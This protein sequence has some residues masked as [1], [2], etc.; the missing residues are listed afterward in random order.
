VKNKVFTGGDMSKVELFHVI[1][2]LE[3]GERKRFTD[4]ETILLYTGNDRWFNDVMYRYRPDV[5]I[6]MYASM[7]RLRGSTYS[8]SYMGESYG[9]GSSC[10]QQGSVSDG[11]GPSMV[12]WL[13][14]GEE[15]NDEEDQ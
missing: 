14:D 4:I 11:S 7:G 5:R 1:K 8:A 3:I 13:V 9:L 12:I 10:V 15:Q 6:Q 2:D